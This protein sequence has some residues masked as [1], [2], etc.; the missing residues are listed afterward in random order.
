MENGIYLASENGHMEVV[1][2]LR[3]NVSMLI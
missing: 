1:N 2:Y 3:E